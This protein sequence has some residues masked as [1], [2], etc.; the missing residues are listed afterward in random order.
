M[1]VDGFDVFLFLL[2]G[3]LAG[4][5]FVVDHGRRGGGRELPQGYS[6]ETFPVSVDWPR[7][8]GFVREKE[9]R[10]IRFCLIWIQMT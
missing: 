9:R 2:R 10:R 4:W 5:T 7:R 1:E 6:S 3:I 8:V